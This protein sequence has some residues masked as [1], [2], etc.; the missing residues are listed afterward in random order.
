[1]P[2]LERSPRL[3]QVQLSLPQ[4]AEDLPDV[5]IVTATCALNPLPSSVI[6]PIRIQALCSLLA[7]QPNQ[8]LVH[9]VAQGRSFGF[10][11]G[12]RGIAV[13]SR[14]RNL[15]SEEDNPRLVT[16]ALVR[17]VRRGHVAGPLT[18][19]LPV[20]CCSPLGSVP[21]S[22][23]TVRFILDCLL[24]VAGQSMRIYP[25]LIF[26]C[27]TP[28]LTMR[29]GEWLTSGRLVWQTLTFNMLLASAQCV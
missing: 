20:L 23:G 18:S 29:C 16:S 1:M 28:P 7:A 21:K 22:N 2:F 6:T 24:L 19:P 27:L 3:C 4:I 17:E 26:P 8:T 14:P 12:F 11:I 9:F 25:N 5:G 15:R 10:D 13:P